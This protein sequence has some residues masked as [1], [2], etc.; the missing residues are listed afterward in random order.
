MS[1]TKTAIKWKVLLCGM[2]ITICMSSSAMAYSRT[3]AINYSDQYAMS[4]NPSYEYYA[5]NDCA[6]FVS[7]CFYTGGLNKSGTWY[8][9]YNSDGEMCGTSAWVNADALKNYVKGLN[10]TRLGNWS[11]YGTSGQYSTYAYVNNS[12]NLTSANTGKTVVFYDWTGD[13]EMDH[14]SIFVANNAK[15]YNTDAD[16]NVTGDLISQHSNNRRRVIWNRDKAN[17]QRNTTRIYAFELPV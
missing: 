5:G 10:A 3:A 2:G 4:P 8:T 11:K 6:N 12:A 15:T 9:Y 17:R 7:Q 16:G 1:F 14:S 13:G